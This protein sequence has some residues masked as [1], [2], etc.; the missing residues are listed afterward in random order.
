MKVM[1]VGLNIETSKLLRRL[2]SIMIPLKTISACLF[3][4]LLYI[5]PANSAEIIVTPGIQIEGP[6]VRSLVFSVHAAP[7]LAGVKLVLEFNPSEYTYTTL[8]KTKATQNMMH[9][10]N[11]KHPGKLIVVM[12]SATGQSASN[13]DL[14]TLA[15]TSQGTPPK[16]AG[17][18][19]KVTKVELMSSDLVEIPCTDTVITLD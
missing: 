4:L 16:S 5:L 18:A 1:I 19:L 9:V 8:R 7:K 14:F 17:L 3:I 2:F 15:F 11:D 12:A 6:E 10:V 13:V